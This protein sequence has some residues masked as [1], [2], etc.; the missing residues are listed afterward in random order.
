MLCV[1]VV[2]SDP[3]SQILIDD[4]SYPTDYKYIF[5]LT[6]ISTL[7]FGFTIN[8]RMVRNYRNV[9]TAQL[10]IKFKPLIFKIN[11]DLLIETF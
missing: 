2:E 8:V 11:D 10:S 9:S 6:C 7:F 4:V 5:I 1:H 3:F